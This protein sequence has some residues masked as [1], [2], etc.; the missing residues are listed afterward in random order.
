[1]HAKGLIIASLAALSSAAAVCTAKPC[2]DVRIFL[3]RGT[4]EPY[5]GRQKAIAEAICKEFDSCTFENVQYP[6]S[7]NTYCESAAA[8]VTNT[9]KAVTQY[10][11][12]CPDSKIILTGWS[13]G[14]HVVGDALGGAEETE[15]LWGGCTQPGN[16]GIDPTTSP[17][18]QIIA[19]LM[20]G[21]PRHTTGQIY[22]LLSGQEVDGL[23]PRNKTELASLN[24]YTNILRDYCLLDDPACAGGADWSIHSSY[25][26]KY[27]EDAVQFVKFKYC[28]AST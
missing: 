22:N 20:W 8:G 6:A 9:I 23:G 25:F 18:N 28:E 21:S 2:T 13:Q 15:W 7:Y 5:P 26:D 24:K 11:Q 27:W 1:M 3:V 14:A 17:G 19:A 12:R 10:G 16:V 4:T